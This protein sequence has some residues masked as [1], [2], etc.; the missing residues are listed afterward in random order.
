MFI[1]TLI[2][3]FSNNMIPDFSFSLL[4]EIHKYHAYDIIFLLPYL[5]VFSYLKRAQKHFIFIVWL[6]KY[7]ATQL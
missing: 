7:N 6:L 1:E 2:L 4:N 3:Y 5:S